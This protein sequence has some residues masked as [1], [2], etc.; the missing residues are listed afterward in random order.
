MHSP[1]TLL[2]QTS[3][4][5]VHYFPRQLMTA[6]DMLAEQEYFRQKLRRHNRFLH[7]WG[8]VCGGDVKPYPD[9][10]HPWRVR[11][12]PGYL[13]TPQGD[14]VC[15]AEPMNFDMAGDWRQGND[16][17]THLSPCPPSGVR[18]P[19]DQPKNVYL[20]ACYTECN[21]RP[22]RVHPVGC[23]CDEAACE[24][25]RIRDSFELRR[26][27]ELPESHKLAAEAD[28]RWAEQFQKWIKDGAK[29][30]PPVPECPGC[31]HDTCV[32]L[33]SITLPDK[34]DTAI[35]AQNISYEGR[36]VLHSTAALHPHVVHNN[37]DTA[38]RKPVRD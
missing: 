7:G 16:P 13:I 15:I 8:M 38:T 26:L 14:E 28:K 24:Y 10:D 34:K 33:A 30:P 22:V 23:A 17:C 6:D 37:T 35:T 20:A 5:R 36:R 3:L 21:T 1:V 4:E 2:G 11:V 19:P 27:L 9:K 12:C 31:P 18:C 25:S 32:V 29:P